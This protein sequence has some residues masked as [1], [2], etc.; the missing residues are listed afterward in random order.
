MKLGWQTQALVVVVALSVLIGGG[1]LLSQMDLRGEGDTLVIYTYSSLL[2]YGDDPEA[3]KQIVFDDFGDEHDVDVEL[4]I[5]SDSGP[6]IAAL[7]A[8]K[9][10]PIADIVI[11]ID[12]IACLSVLDEG[13]L[14]PYDSPMLDNIDQSLIDGLDSEN[15]LIPFDYGVLALVYN[16]TRMPTAQFPS[17]E[18]IELSDLTD[19]AIANRLVIENP[20]TSSPGQAFLLWQ[21]GIYQE[22]LDQDW[23][24]FW[25]QIKDEVMITDGWSEAWDMAFGDTSND[26]DMMVSYGT[27]G[28]YNSH[29]GWGTNDA[30]VSHED[31]Q[32]WTWFQIEGIGIVEGTDNLKT[33]KEFIDHFLDET[34]QSLIPLNQWMYPANNEATLPDCY[35]DAIDPTTV[36]AV[37]DLFTTEELEQNLETWLLEW[38]NIMTA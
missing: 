14:I 25:N 4:K 31:G 20:E 11:G 38:K 6:M 7:R 23:K 18:S 2:E 16:S 22:V 8:E 24:T 3:V 30:Q 27:D 21:I 37:N 32:E 35:D 12:N 15:R 9:N 17:L 33:A 29:Y 34:V 19:D 26:I 28:A 13:L 36:N 1:I 10:N 5:F